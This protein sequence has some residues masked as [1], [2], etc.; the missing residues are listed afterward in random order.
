MSEQQESLIR[1]QSVLMLARNRGRNNIRN[2]ILTKFLKCI[3][4]K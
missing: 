4:G 1:G 3:K 2:K